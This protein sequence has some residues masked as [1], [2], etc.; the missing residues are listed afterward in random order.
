MLGGDSC[1][2]GPL[3][4][5]AAARDASIQWPRVLPTHALEKCITS[6]RSYTMQ[7][8][9]CLR[10]PTPQSPIKECSAEAI[11]RH[12]CRMKTF[13]FKFIYDL[14]FCQLQSSLLRASPFIMD[15]VY[16]QYSP[17]FDVFVSFLFIMARYI[18]SFN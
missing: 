6:F 10:Q 5:W 3:C 16:N 18:R 4:G 12:V 14:F 2:S 17:R 9:Q 7:P 11:K 1:I 13:Y 15:V 8:T